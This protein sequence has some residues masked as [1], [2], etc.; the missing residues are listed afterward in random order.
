M[1]Y[2]KDMS[3]EFYT[4]N[5]YGSD[6]KFVTSLTLERNSSYVNSCD[7]ESA[8]W[9]M[10]KDNLILVLKTLKNTAE[11][12]EKDIKDFKIKIVKYVREDVTEDFKEYYEDK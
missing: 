11:K 2:D 9:F 5:L 1:I 7:T 4:V 8:A 3:K 12:D 10:E 6:T